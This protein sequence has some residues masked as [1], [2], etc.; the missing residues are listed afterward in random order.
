[1]TG[2]QLMF[3][4]LLPHPPSLSRWERDVALPPRLETP[5]RGM[6]LI[7]PDFICSNKVPFVNMQISH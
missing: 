1:M 3:G 5:T 4:S 2:D 7:A 6:C